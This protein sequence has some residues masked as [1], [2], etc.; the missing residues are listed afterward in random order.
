MKQIE[1]YAFLSDAL[2]S[3]DA[4]KEQLEGI[5]EAIGKGIDWDA[6]DGTETHPDR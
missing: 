5:R 4:L 1:M 3:L 2:Q 6:M